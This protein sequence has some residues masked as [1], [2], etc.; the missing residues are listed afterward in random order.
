VEYAL[1]FHEL[2]IDSFTSP[3]IV[4]FIRHRPSRRSGTA[5]IS[6]NL[7]RLRIAL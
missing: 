7:K 3:I 6:M 1:Y 2:K 4:Q 5:F